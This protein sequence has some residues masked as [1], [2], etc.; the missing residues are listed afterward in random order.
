MS[1]NSL[2]A[3]PMNESPKG[4]PGALEMVGLA[5]VAV[6]LSGWKPRGT[7]TEGTVMWLYEIRL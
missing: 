7:V 5:G 2:N 3:V 4:T 1:W 6:I